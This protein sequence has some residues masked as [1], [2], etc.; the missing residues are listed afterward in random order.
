M[1]RRISLL[2]TALTLATAPAG[3]QAMPRLRP[4]G[5]TDSAVAW[6]EV[7]FHGPAHCSRCHGIRG[8]G[9]DRGPALTDAVWLHGPG[10]YEWLVAQVNHGV[11]REHSATGDSMPARGAAPM[12]VWDV[13]A[14]AA[15]VWAISHP[16]EPPPREPPRPN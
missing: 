6:G 14:V 3:A 11:S 10:T 15:Y 2:L 5:V 8:R 13:R 4:P 16:P 12:P 1:V 7:L 9:T